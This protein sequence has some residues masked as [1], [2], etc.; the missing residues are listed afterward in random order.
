MLD[1]TTLIGARII[2]AAGEKPNSSTMTSARMNVSRLLMKWLRE[3]ESQS[4]T[5]GE[6]W[7][8]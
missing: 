1:Q 4:S 5:V 8:A 6:W 2:K 3:A 7:M